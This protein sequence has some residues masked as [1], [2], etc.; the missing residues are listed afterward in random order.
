MERLAEVLAER[1]EAIDRVTMS[2]STEPA[3]R[4]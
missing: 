1:N 3:L 2:L 4:W